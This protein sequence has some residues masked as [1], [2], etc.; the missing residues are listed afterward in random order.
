MYSAHLQFQLV[1]CLSE[2]RQLGDR[3]AAA[4]QPSLGEV[5]LLSVSQYLLNDRFR[6]RSFRLDVMNIVVEL[7]EGSGTSASLPHKRRQRR[8]LLNHFLLLHE[9]AR[10]HISWVPVHRLGQLALQTRDLLVDADDHLHKRREVKREKRR[11]QES[12]RETMRQIRGCFTWFTKLKGLSLILT[13]LLILSTPLQQDLG[14]SQLFTYS[15]ILFS[16][17]N[18]NNSKQ[19]ESCFRYTSYHPL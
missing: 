10:T 19:A 8:V 4:D 17:N 3:L 15:Q 18:N 5:T 14:V 13:G 12:M 11:Q 2:G 7:H 16:T 6:L 1:Q 9:A